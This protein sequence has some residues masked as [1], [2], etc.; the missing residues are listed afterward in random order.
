MNA[1]QIAAV[2][3]DPAS[4]AVA[5]FLS[6]LETKEAYRLLTIWSEEGVFEL[7][8]SH[9]AIPGMHHP[10]FEGAQRIYEL[11]KGVGA[12]KDIECKDIVFFPMRDPEYVY[13]E[14]FC[15]IT[16]LDLGIKYTNR[17]CGL[18]H[19]RDGEIVLFR[20]YFHALIRQSFEATG[21]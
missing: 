8:F 2:T 15:D 3:T 4:K 14:F 12:A 7:P 21:F 16:Q 9:K 18:A 13:V 17:Y 10:K 5:E 1:T 6:V 20:E 19:V 11:F